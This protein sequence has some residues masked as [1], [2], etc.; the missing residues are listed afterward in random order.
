MAQRRQNGD[1]FYR[2]CARHRATKVDEE[3]SGDAL[4]GSA[5]HD[6]REIEEGD[7]SG[8]GML[9]IFVLTGFYGRC[10]ENSIFSVQVAFTARTCASTSRP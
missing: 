5:V 10:M 3:R 6:L 8:R 9:V 4:A 7:Q 2:T 1:Q